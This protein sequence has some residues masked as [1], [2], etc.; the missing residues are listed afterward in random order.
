MS[1]A[2]RAG[3]AETVIAGA[4]PNGNGNASA[5]RNTDRPPEAGAETAAGAIGW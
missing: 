3:A 4:G 5:G 1:A 2:A